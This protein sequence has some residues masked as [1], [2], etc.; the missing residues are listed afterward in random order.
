M[1]NWDSSGTSTSFPPHPDDQPLLGVRLPAEVLPNDV[2]AELAA[3]GADSTSFSSGFAQFGGQSFQCW[4]SGVSAT[5]SSI[6]RKQGVPSVFLV[7]DFATVDRT[8]AECQ[9]ILDLVIKIFGLLGLELNPA[10]VFDPSQLV[11]FLCVLIDSVRRMVSLVPEK[12]ALYD[13]HVGLTL[14]ADANG[15][16]VVNALESQLGEL[17]WFS[18]VL[19]VRRSRPSRIRACIPGG[20]SYRPHP[21]KRISLSPESKADLWWRKQLQ[22]AAAHLRFVPFWT[23]PRSCAISSQ[24]QRGMWALVWLW[25]IRSI[26]QGLWQK[27]V[28]GESSCFKSSCPFSLPL[29]CSPRRPTAT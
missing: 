24:M 15:S 14:E 12:M 21:H 18:E 28:L 4:A 13:Q 8:K 3:T 5:G 19:V 26:R 20:G 7:D 25:G 6:L 17:G 29:R 10:K 2:A 9:R 11:E 1:A 27:E 23:N 22:V 16:L